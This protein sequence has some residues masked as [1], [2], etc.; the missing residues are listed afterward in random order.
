MNNNYSAYLCRNPEHEFSGFFRS[1]IGK[2]KR[3]V[4]ISLND[5]NQAVRDSA[6]IGLYFANDA[7]VYIA[8]TDKAT[9]A[10]FDVGDFGKVEV[11]VK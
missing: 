2:S 1:L 5:S 3:E 4:N 9:G 11:R 10:K 8:F 6:S 7:C